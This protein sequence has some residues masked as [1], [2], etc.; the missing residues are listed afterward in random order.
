MTIFGHFLIELTKYGHLSQFWGP[1]SRFDHIFVFFG[2]KN[3]GIGE[4]IMLLSC[5][6][7]KLSS[8]QVM[9][10]YGHTCW[11]VHIWAYENC[12]YLS[13]WMR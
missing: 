12:P 9:P 11:Y 5:S 4:K 3:E 6:A 13:P 1:M 10:I 2:Y 7:Q 8:D